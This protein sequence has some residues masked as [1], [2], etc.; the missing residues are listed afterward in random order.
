MASTLKAVETGHSDMIHDAQLDYYGKILATASSDRTV[1]LFDVEENSALIAELKGHEGPVWQVSWS[2][3][4]FGTHLASCSYDKR[5]IVWKEVSKGSWSKV[6]E[7][8]KHELSVNSVAWAPHELGLCF[9]AASSDGSISIHTFKETSWDSQKFPAHQIGVNAISWAPST[10]ALTSSPANQFPNIPRLVS[11]GC[12]NLVK[13][14]RYQDNQWHPEVLPQKSN[15]WIRDVAWAP[16]LG[17]PSNIIATCSQDGTV[18]IWTEENPN[19]WKPIELKRFPDVVWR[20]SWS[21]T[22]NILAVSSGDNDVTLWK[23][24]LTGHWE[25]ISSMNG[26]GECLRVKE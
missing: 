2:H 8:D 24:S 3:P 15:D 23:E 19:S 7:Y 13:I 11:G 5:V 21:V 18:V 20:V 12:D 6:Y 17:L 14:W 4:R 22:G 1:K 16:S 25:C 9:A 10:S 26:D